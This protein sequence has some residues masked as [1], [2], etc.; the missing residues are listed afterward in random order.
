MLAILEIVIKNEPA[1]DIHS[2]KLF[3]WTLWFVKYSSNLKI[4]LNES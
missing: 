3:F 1:N 2:T 4:T